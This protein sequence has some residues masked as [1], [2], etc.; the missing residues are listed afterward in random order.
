MSNANTAID[1]RIEIVEKPR[2]D[3]PG[4]DWV[5]RFADVENSAARRFQSRELAEDYAREMD[6]MLT[7]ENRWDEINTLREVKA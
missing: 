7:E 1:S 2:P 4:W 3:A 6:V 5:V